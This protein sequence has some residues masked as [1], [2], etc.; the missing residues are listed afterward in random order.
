MAALFE[1]HMGNIDE[2]GF[3]GGLMPEQVQINTRPSGGGRSS[4][5]GPTPFTHAL[6]DARSVVVPELTRDALDMDILKSIVE[7]EG[8][9]ITSRQ[10]RGNVNRWNPSAL[11]VAI[12]NNCP[13]FGERPPDG[14][15]RRVN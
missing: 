2:G 7:Q 13:D 6:K 10:C 12:G 5:D 4:K 11:L 14:T 3:G 1:S 15:E 8:A 9:K